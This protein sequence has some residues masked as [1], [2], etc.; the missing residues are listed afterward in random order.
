MSCCVVL[1]NTTGDHVIGITI[2]YA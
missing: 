2:D 1:A